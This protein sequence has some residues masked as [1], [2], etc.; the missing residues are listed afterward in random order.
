MRWKVLKA[1]TT[2]YWFNS[3]IHPWRRIWKS[4]APLRCKFFLWLA[5]KQRIWTADRL[6]KRDFPHQDACP[7]C[8]QEQETAQ[9][10]LSCAFTRQ[11]WAVV[12]QHLNLVVAGPTTPTTSFSAWWC[13]SIK[14]VPKDL[15]KGLNSLI[16]LVTWEIWKHRNSCV[17][18]GARPSVQVLLQQ[19]SSE[20]VLWCSAGATKLK[21]L[22]A[23]LSQQAVWVL[24]FLF[25]LWSRFGL[26]CK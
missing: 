22:L 3:R 9:H 19:V 6:A 10:L 7:L 14:S 18:E 24:I 2:R 1:K 4:W 26:C 11:V 21:E 23:R 5:I 8:D 12:F 13:S 15:K 25:G 17:F 16:I 20:C